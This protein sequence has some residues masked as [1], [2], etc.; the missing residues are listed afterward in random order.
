MRHTPCLPQNQGEEDLKL[1]G[2]TCPPFTGA[3]EELSVEQSKSLPLEA[4]SSFFSR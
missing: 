1:Q 4:E 3:L 2:K